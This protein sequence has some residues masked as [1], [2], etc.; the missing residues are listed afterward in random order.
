MYWGTPV[1]GDASEV[2]GSLKGLRLKGA[3]RNMIFAQRSIWA[4]YLSSIPP[5]SQ[6]GYAR[7]VEV[8]LSYGG[9]PHRGEHVRPKHMML[10]MIWVHSFGFPIIWASTA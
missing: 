10:R 3:Q 1:F 2:R 5:P 9:I 8:Y 7:I 6:L 4:Q